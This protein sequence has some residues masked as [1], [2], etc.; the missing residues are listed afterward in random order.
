VRERVRDLVAD[1]LGVSVTGPTPGHTVSARVL[2]AAL[3]K[4]PGRVSRA[5]LKAAAFDV[6]ADRQI[7]ELGSDPKATARNATAAQKRA[8]S[9][10]ALVERLTA[11][12]NGHGAGS[13]AEDLMQA[14]KRAPVLTPPANG[15]A[16][17]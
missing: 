10:L 2:D 17:P 5:I 12:G 15:D 14:L 7:A 3:A 1:Y 16:E 9:H 8:D 13:P 4:L 6:L 11:K